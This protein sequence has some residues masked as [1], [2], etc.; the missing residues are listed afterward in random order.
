[1]TM[2]DTTGV[3]EADS[4]QTAEEKTGALVG[5]LFG[6][7][8]GAVDVV[9]V[10]LGDRL[11][12]YRV[13]AEAGPV[14]SSEL[15]LQSNIDERYALEWLEQQAV[16]GILDVDDAG[17]PAG[18]RRYQL[19]PAHAQALIDLDSMYSISP[20]ARSFVAAVQALPQ[21]MKAFRTGGG[22]RWSA[23]GPDMI[24]SQGD[25][26][27][28]WL[29]N[30]LGTEYLPSIPDLH[31]RL[32][33]DPPAR[34]ADVACG[35]GWASIAIARAYPKVTVDGF[36][37]DDSS[38]E[39]ARRLATEAGVDDRVR[40]QVRDGATIGTEG[41]YDLAIVIESIHDLSRPVEVLEGI[42]HSL[43]PEG[44]LIV[45]DEKVSESFTTPGNEVDRLM[46]GF[47]FLVCLPSG[48][49]ERPSAATGTVMRPDTFR[50]YASEAGFSKVD[51]LDQIQ[52]DF[53]RFFRLTP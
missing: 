39:I 35:V 21:V 13:L 25:F 40:F 30:L 5:R 12:L 48:L 9:S 18:D 44:T 8:L 27:R 22:V 29:L 37:C 7:A 23:F 17:K 51:L 1:M 34:V 43:A 50:R 36:D 24:E 42:R 3:A 14:T 16:T 32:Q 6:A 15:A 53:L 47:S 26:N 2:E 31:Q 52:H 49:S 45:A 28:P 19:P 10:Y 20:L 33:A 41:P 46:Y 4:A 38:I 11:G